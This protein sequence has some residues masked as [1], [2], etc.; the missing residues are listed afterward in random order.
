MWANSAILGSNNCTAFSPL[1]T[2]AMSNWW[3]VFS[4]QRKYGL[5]GNSVLQVA[6]FQAVV[7]DKSGWTSSYREILRNPEERGRYF[8]ASGLFSSGSIFYFCSYSI[9]SHGVLAF[10]MGLFSSIALEN[11]KSK[12]REVTMGALQSLWFIC[13]GKWTQ[14]SRVLYRRGVCVQGWRLC[15]NAEGVHRYGMCK[16]RWSVC[17]GM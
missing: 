4:R 15:T 14:R 13:R 12:Y 9:W 6:H 11:S 2:P 17:I 7:E 16:Q 8:V 10:K 1:P 5:P 3:L